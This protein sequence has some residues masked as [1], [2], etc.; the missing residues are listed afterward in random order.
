[1]ST[2]LRDEVRKLLRTCYL[3][4]AYADEIAD[5]IL[6]LIS[7]KENERLRAENESLRAQIEAG[8]LLPEVD[9][10]GEIARGQYLCLCRNWGGPKLRILF[11]PDDGWMFEDVIHGWGPM[12]EAGKE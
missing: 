7:D 9:L 2:N 1:M 6:Y 8:L 12:P 3:S 5:R 10:A 4:N 11:Y